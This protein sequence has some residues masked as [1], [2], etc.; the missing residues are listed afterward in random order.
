MI[1]SPNYHRKIIILSA[2]ILII[3][4]AVLSAVVFG[5]LYKKA[6]ENEQEHLREIAQSRARILEA[7][8]R[9]EYVH[10]KDLTLSST[11]NQLINA[12]H[13][14]SGFNETG[15]LIIGKREADQIVFL[16]RHHHSVLDPPAPVPFQSKLAE[17]M[18]RAL[19]GKAGIIVGLDYRQVMVVAAYEPVSF[20]NLGVVA[21]I[22]LSEIQAPFIQTIK[23]VLLITAL[24]TSIGVIAFLNF[25]NPIIVRML[26]SESRLRSILEHAPMIIEMRDIQ[27]RYLLVN[28]QHQSSFRYDPDWIIGK[29]V[30]E[31]FSKQIAHQ[32]R[33][34]DKLVQTTRK[35][36]AIEEKIFQDNQ[37]HTYL[38]VNFPI[39]DYQDHLQAIGN[40]STD[41]TLQKQTTEELTIFKQF[42]E[43]AGEGMGMVTLD[44]QI[45]YLNNT[46]ATFLQTE[47]QDLL[48]KNFSNYYPPKLQ[49]DLLIKI[50]PQL[51]E[52]GQW[53]GER[54]LIAGQGKVI[55]TL[56]NYFLML[57][58][59]GKPSYIAFVINDISN[60][61][62]MEKVLQQSQANLA[63]AQQI[64]HLGSWE[65]EIQ[66][67]K[68]QWS[69]EQYRI[70]GYEPGEIPASYDLFLNVL[71]PHDKAKVLKAVDEVLKGK[72]PY[73]LEFRI[74]LPNHEERT[75]LAQGEVYRDS[76][77]N[78]IRM[79]GTVLDITE[80]KQAEQQLR[81]S[82]ER[83]RRLFDEGPIG[84]VIGNM[85]QQFIKVNLAFCQM[86][87]YSEAE[88]L[89]LQ[90][91]DITYPEDML[92]NQELIS[93]ALTGKIP[94]YQLE[95]RYL[96]KDGQIVWGH[97]AV[98]IFF[99]D[100]GQPLYFL[101]KVEDITN[102][103]QA[104]EALRRSEAM[105]MRA[106][107]IAHLGIWEWNLVKD[108]HI[109]SDETYTLLGY[110]PHAIEPTFKNF[111]NQVHPQ[112]KT[113]ILKV[114]QQLVSNRGVVTRQHDEF[115]IIRSDNT[116][117]IIES[118]TQCD[119]DDQGHLL[120]I[121]GT[122]LDITDRKQIE[123]ALKQA[124][125]AADA[126]NQAKSEFL[127]NMSHEIRTPLNAVIGFSEL[128]STYLM[129]S[130]AKSYLA[131]IQTAGKALLTLIND[132]LDLSKIEA[133]RLEIQP[134]PT[135]L[136]IIITELTQLFSLPIAEK[137]LDFIVEIDPALP[138]TLVLDETR[139]RQVLLNLI[140][141]AVKF[142]EQ[143]YI[144]LSVQG[145]LTD[146]ANK[147]DLTIVVA[148]SGIGIPADQQE[149]I[150]AAFQQQEGQSN[151]KYGGTG[152]GLAI[153]KRLTEMMQGQILV[154]SQIDQGSTFEIKLKDVIIK[155]YIVEKNVTA[156]F[157]LTNIA[158]EPNQTVLVVDDIKCNRQLI[159]EALSQVQLK[160]LE[161]VDGQQG[162]L[163]AEECQPD[164]ILMDIKMPIMSGYESVKYLKANPH[165]QHIP[166]I[167]LTATAA[168][169]YATI[170]AQRFDRFLPKP[171][172]ISELLKEISVYLKHTRLSVTKN[173]KQ[174][175]T[176]DIASVVN[177]EQ[178]AE[179]I[180]KLE[181][182][183]LEWE[184]I[185]DGL[186][187]ER[188]GKFSEQIQLLG[189]E[190]Q[191][192]QLSNY[193]ESL[194][195]SILIFNIEQIEKILNQFPEWITLLKSKVQ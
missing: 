27:G 114:V 188:I 177:L 183:L 2:A 145:K 170:E 193:G 143:G 31:L 142:T 86:L 168:G 90:I 111:L 66:T 191:F 140:G 172:H 182:H 16:L 180:A 33:E 127:A 155:N 189:E 10:V 60:R 95:K 184:E 32:F 133:G 70:F 14:Y 178:L 12:Y 23:W 89:Q 104:E 164:L 88:L 141:N 5:V 96:R 53:S 156:I 93:L 149:K 38:S 30:D 186:D 6:F 158:F 22:N 47:P 185:H 131:A 81:H 65:W 77:G 135:D 150:F 151:R 59:M 46:L 40:I 91:T 110:E 175:D 21:K 121:L 108:R 82:E 24:I 161:A 195:E 117:H 109:W 11:L 57:D 146:D 44:Q 52:T 19:S 115:R 25:V 123:M 192:P 138:A 124:K 67:G 7:I 194:N 116:E 134:E 43:T 56:E 148:D 3:A 105:L 87:G 162:L 139:L 75:I 9:V 92:K 29:T 107:E 122:L 71:H 153:T 99:D 120:R 137:G 4:T 176:L 106:Q 181:A 169:E 152:L 83:F 129:D 36:L 128:L 101:A 74:V 160:V 8:A 28:R 130:K 45:V 119:F 190:Y 84:M 17:P 20:L 113:K 76:D 157:N 63:K 179:L 79:L 18:R 48:G 100:A 72:Q 166:V 171:I 103:K 94:N 154:S 159:Q 136:T 163:V 61:K 69:D 167:A 64:A 35:P 144:K 80:H 85:Q 13:N 147:L 42:V 54:Q 39:F 187:L 68:E 132:I 112:D 102:R 126:A 26:E 97:L 34:N 118:T 37:W 51:L 173:I 49:P 98:S 15:E 73:H 125:R 58:S 78:P 41:I 165:T 55:D 1:K 62:Q 50:L 174:P